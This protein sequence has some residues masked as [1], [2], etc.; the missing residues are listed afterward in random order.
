MLWGGY[1][2]T[3]H[4]LSFNKAKGMPIFPIISD[5]ATLS[6]LQEKEA[7]RDEL[8]SQ[9]EQFLAS[10][11]TID[12]VEPNVMADPPKKPTSNYGSQPI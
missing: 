3:Q 12:Y 7:E 6:D 2:M 5:E 9:I 8:N 4:E 10:G 1:T 11:G